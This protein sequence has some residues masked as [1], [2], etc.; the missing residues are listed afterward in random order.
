MYIDLIFLH[1][2]K[3]AR[4]N[5]EVF[6]L[7]HFYLGKQKLPLLEKELFQNCINPQIPFRQRSL[8]IYDSH[9]HLPGT[10]LKTP[11]LLSW[12]PFNRQFA[13]MDFNC[14]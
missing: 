8:A 4:E 6:C 1:I 12:R 9:W 2:H 11:D 5:S 10:Q 7:V 14:D 3:P 13:Q